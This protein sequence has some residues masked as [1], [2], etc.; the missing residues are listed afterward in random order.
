[1]GDPDR[2]P[3]L[4]LHSQVIAIAVIAS[5]LNKI[6]N[7]KPW[8]ERAAFATGFRLIVPSYLRVQNYL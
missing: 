1:M 4:M 5:G 3:K 6:K 8:G 7:P 2:R